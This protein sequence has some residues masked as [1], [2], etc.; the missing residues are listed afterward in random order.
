MISTL[1]P[2]AFLAQGAMAQ[3]ANMGDASVATIVT[4]LI[5]NGAIFAVSIGVFLLLRNKFKVI[6]SP[7]TFLGPEDERTAPQNPTLFGWIPAYIKA[8]KYSI[9]H[10]QGLDAF[11][12]LEYLEMMVSGLD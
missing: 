5:L 7:K 9:L 3:S 4:A 6:Y 12:F 11:M 1:I 8:D 10:K 2:L